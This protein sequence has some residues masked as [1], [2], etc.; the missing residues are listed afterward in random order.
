MNLLVEIFREELL[1]P[2]QSG[3]LRICVANHERLKSGIVVTLAG[4][5][6]FIH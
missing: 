3:C 4:L 6:G 1:D 5:E 2:S